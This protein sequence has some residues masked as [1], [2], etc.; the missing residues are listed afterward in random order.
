MLQA[1]ARLSRKL[2][3]RLSVDI[4]EVGLVQSPAM[5]DVLSSPKNTGEIQLPRARE[6]PLRAGP[7]SCGPSPRPTRQPEGCR[8]LDEFWA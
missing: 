8:G 7:R 2:S 6:P 3:A 4:L 5:P 1:W